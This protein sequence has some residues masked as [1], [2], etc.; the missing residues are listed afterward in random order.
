MKATIESISYFLPNT[1]LDNDRLAREWTSWTADK[2]EAKTGV[3]TRHIASEDECASDLAVKA[4]QQLFAKGA[5]NPSEIDFLLLCTQ[6]PDYFLPTTACLLQSRLGLPQSCGALDFNLGCSGFIYGLGLAKGLI[7]SGQV[8]NVLLITAE[9]YSKFLHPQDRSVRAIFGDGAAATLVRGVETDE[10]LLGPFVYGTDGTGGENLIVPTGGL[11]RAT[12][13]DPDVMEDSDGNKRTIN[14]LY[15]NGPEIFNFTLK[16]V[17]KCFHQLIAVSGKRL[18]DIDWFVFHQANQYML[19]YLRKKLQIPQKKFCI[20][21]KDCGNTVSSTI[22]I[23]LANLCR[24]GKLR[25]GHLVMLVGF[26]VGYSWG[27][28]LVRWNANG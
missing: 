17:P 6:S 22:P 19:E 4:A 1:A 25:S 12:V 7:E 27:A 16:A 24:E 9:T 3:R 2:I 14:N 15:M 8:R 21:M 28:S 26:G 20:S 11:R 5:C 18:E 23:S 13:S 10:S